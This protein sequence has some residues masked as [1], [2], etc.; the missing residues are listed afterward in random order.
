MFAAAGFTGCVLKGHCEPTAG[1]ARGSRGGLRGRRVRRHRSQPR[2]RGHQRRGG[3][4]DACARRT[5]CLDADARRARS[6]RTRAAAAG[7]MAHRRRPRRTAG[8]Q[9]PRR[10]RGR[11]PAARRRGGRSIATGHLGPAECGWLV[12]R[13]R[14]AGVRRVLLTHPTFAVPG[15]AP[16]EVEE[17][18]AMGAIAEITAYQSWVGM[19]R[20]RSPRWPGGSGPI[21]VSS[22]AMPASP[23]RLP[24]PRHSQ[25]WSSG[26]SAPAWTRE[27]PMRWRRRRPAASRIAPAFTA[28][29]DTSRATS[30]R[31]RRGA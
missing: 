1:R 10:R 23:S 8:G 7:R 20:R 5:H 11:H 21:A 2:R 24:R 6:S 26:W 30:A 25:S 4:G 16:A 15:L 18:C 3:V 22:R 14:A 29:A 27:L 13:A 28:P 31:C 17:L 9:P 12:R 19:T